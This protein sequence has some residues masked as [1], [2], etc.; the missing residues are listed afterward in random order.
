MTASKAI[1]DGD[2]ILFRAAANV[3]TLV[4]AYD[5]YQNILEEYTKASWCEESIVFIEGPGNWRR[6]I[7]EYYKANRTSAKQDEKASEI[8]FDLSMYLE[9]SKLVIKAFGMESDDLVGRYAQKCMD[10]GKDYVVISADKDLDC[11]PGVHYRPNQWGQAKTYSVTEDEAKYNYLYQLL[12][13]D[14]IDNIKSPKG[15]GP[16]AAQGILKGPLE[17]WEDK[18]EAAYKERCGSHWLEALT[19][20]GSLT[21]IQRYKDEMFNWRGNG[22]WK[23]LGFSGIPTSYTYTDKQLGKA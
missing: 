10:R 16:K 7:F 12:I 17:T 3:D 1:V 23:D 15:L 6:D 22:T 20:T 18:V 9:E 21:H 11:I 8:R 14:G 13:G 5:K 2:S 4:Q 19:F